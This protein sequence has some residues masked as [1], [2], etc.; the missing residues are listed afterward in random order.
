MIYSAISLLGLLFDSLISVFDDFNHRVRL[1]SF[2][3][4]LLLT[5]ELGTLRVRR[6]LQTAR[7]A[8]FQWIELVARGEVVLDAVRVLTRTR[9]NCLLG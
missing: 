4:N 7:I 1:L 2:V 6:W 5:M 3:R 8:L 9:S